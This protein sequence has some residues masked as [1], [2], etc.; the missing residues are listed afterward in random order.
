[1]YVHVGSVTPLQMALREE[2]IVTQLI[3][4]SQFP[5]LTYPSASVRNT[6]VG[7]VVNRSIMLTCK[8]LGF[9]SGDSEECRLFGCH[10]MW[11]L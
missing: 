3:K 6:S 10:A 8:I 7:P 5:A 11:L 9:H 4:P 2:S 1:M